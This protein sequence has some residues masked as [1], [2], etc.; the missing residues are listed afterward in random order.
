MIKAWKKRQWCDR[1]RFRCI[2]LPAFRFGNFGNGRRRHTGSGREPC[3]CRLL[4]RG[5][6]LPGVEIGKGRGG[7]GCVD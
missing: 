2:N 5:E 1:G 4:V 7:V 3:I 6:R